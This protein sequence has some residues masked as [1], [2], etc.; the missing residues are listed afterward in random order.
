VCFNRCHANVVKGFSALWDNIYDVCFNRCH[1][2]VVKGFL[3]LW[4]NI[5][6]YVSLLLYFIPSFLTGNLLVAI[7][8]CLVRFQ[9]LKTASIKMAVFWVLAPC[10]LVLAYRRFTGACCLHHQAI[11]PEDSRVQQRASLAVQ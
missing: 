2:N 8:T 6:D 1:A 3:A 11:N 10:S 4:D 9:V 5:Y 7:I